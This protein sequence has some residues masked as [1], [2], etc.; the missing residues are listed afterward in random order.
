MQCA[1][2]SVCR[3]VQY[4]DVSVVKCSV[5]MCRWFSAVC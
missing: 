5:L 3:L 4:A 2:V 1:D